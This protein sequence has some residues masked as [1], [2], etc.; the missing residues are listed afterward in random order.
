MVHLNY[1]SCTDIWD[2]HKWILSQF[3]YF[4]FTCLIVLSL[5]S[6]LS[7]SSFQLL[8]Q[9][10]KQNPSLLITYSFFF[11]ICPVP[12]TSALLLFSLFITHFFIGNKSS[13]YASIYRTELSY[14][15]FASFPSPLVH[16]SDVLWKLFLEIDYIPLTIII[17]TLF[18]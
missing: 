10:Y 12:S 5:S 15:I 6:P 14:L 1:F 2:H 9:S 16:L 18:F 13:I 4:W 7:S 8:W 3:Y 11:C 17:I